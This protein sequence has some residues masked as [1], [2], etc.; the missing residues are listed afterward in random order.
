MIR[1]VY[2]A[3][4]EAGASEEKAAAAAEVLAGLTRLDARL[5]TLATKEDLAKL[6]A[7][8]ANF[9]TKEDLADLRSELKGDI[10]RLE[11]RLENFA[12][13][14]DLA[15]L[16][17]ELKGDIARLDSRLTAVEAKLAF[18]QW[19]LGATFLAIVALVIRT[20]WP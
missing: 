12:T 15:D 1:E 8:L 18:M 19:M 2:E 16:R 6:E 13:K 11:A 3:L 17:N 4:K 5:E 10:A 20:F 7:R 9:A 14:E